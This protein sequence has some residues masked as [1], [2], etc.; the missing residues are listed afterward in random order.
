MKKIMMALA[1]TTMFAVPASA[2]HS[3]GNAYAYGQG[4]ASA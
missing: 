1:A 4:P 2:D 3:N